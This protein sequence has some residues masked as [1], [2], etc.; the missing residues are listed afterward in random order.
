MLDGLV[1]VDDRRRVRMMNREFRRMFGLETAEPGE[2]LLEVIRHATV[3]RLVVE[4]IRVQEARRGVNPDVAR[5]E[6]RSRDGG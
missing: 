4:A 2:P 3:D 5:A 1:V 6:R